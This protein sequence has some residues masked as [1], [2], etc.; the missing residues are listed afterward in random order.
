MTRLEDRLRRD[1]QVQAEH[2]T[3]PNVPPLRLERFTRDPRAPAAVT[4]WVTRRRLALRSAAVVAAALTAGA[5]ALAVVVVPGARHDGTGGP[6]IDAAYVVKRVD[7]ALSAAGPG[8]IAQM[9]VTTRGALVPGGMTTAEVWSYGGQWHSVIYSSAGHLVYDEGFSTASVYTL[10]SYPTRTWARGPGP[11]SPVAPVP[12]ARGCGSL[13]PASV[14]RALRAAASCGNLTM[15]GR[16]RVDGIEAIE[17]TGRPNGKISET[18]WVNSDTYLPVRVVIRPA[19]GTSGPGQAADITWLK[20]AAQNMAKFTVPIPA[21]FR[22]V[23]LT[24]PVGPVSKPPG[25]P[26][27]KTG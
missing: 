26:L 15:V 22:Q 13:L 21:G 5:V 17:L 9:T 1:L 16:Q 27:P 6:V 8:E 11:G 19:P 12:G 3:P 14:A 2:I 10:V 7:S 25:G 23:P 4:R 24:Q 18:I 20:P